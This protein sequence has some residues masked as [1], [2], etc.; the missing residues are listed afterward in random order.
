[1]GTR[2]KTKAGGGSGQ[3]KRAKP[4]CCCAAAG[5]TT[6]TSS[7]VWFT[8]TLDGWEEVP[9]QGVCSSKKASPLSSPSLPGQAADQGPPGKGR[10]STK[11]RARVA[12]HGRVLGKSSRIRC[13]FRAT[14]HPR[15][16]ASRCSKGGDPSPIFLPFRDRAQGLIDPFPLGMLRRQGRFQNSLSLS[17]LLEQRETSSW[18]DKNIKSGMQT[19]C[20]VESPGYM[21]T[22]SPLC[23]G[24]QV[25]MYVHPLV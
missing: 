5:L 7:M 4:S 11:T 16:A 3:N 13:W 22:T 20:F 10:G 2:R 23:M 1:M 8:L 15:R 6:I 12:L 25:G 18:M 21:I 9:R 19:G 24:E 14:Q 17:P